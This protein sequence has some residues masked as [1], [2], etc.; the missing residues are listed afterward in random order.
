MPRSRLLWVA[1]PMP[2]VRLS[3]PK[4]SDTEVSSKTASMASAMILATDSTANLSKARSAPTG[5][6]SVTTTR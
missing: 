4:M 6:V 2:Q 3:P 5:S 1:G